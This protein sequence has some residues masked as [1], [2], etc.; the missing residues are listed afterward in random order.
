MFGIS[1]L[2]RLESLDMR[3][4]GWSTQLQ[5]LSAHL[6]QTVVSD[7]SASKSLKNIILNFKDWFCLQVPGIVK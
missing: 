1:T 4:C 6:A 7:I 3:L 2:P 5:R